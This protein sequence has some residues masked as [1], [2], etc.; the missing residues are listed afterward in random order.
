MT[1]VR[2]ATNSGFSG[3]HNQGMAACRAEF[4]LVLNSDA[5]LRPGFLRAM[6]DGA[7]AAPRAG[8]FAPR[9]DH[10]D[11]TQQISCFRFPGPRAS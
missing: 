10:D 1:L 6:L 8:L 9:I 11:G 3:G 7:R 5:L 2:S 4:Y